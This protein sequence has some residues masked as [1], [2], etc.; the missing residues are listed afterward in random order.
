MAENGSNLTTN[1]NR[2]LAALL[3][4]RTAEDAAKAAGISRRQLFR[5][6]E[7]PK[8]RLAL[9]Q[10]ETERMSEASRRLLQGQH[11]ALTTLEELLSSPSEQV[12]RQAACDWLSFT[13]KH[14]DNRLDERLGKL[15]EAV[16]GIQ[17]Q[18]D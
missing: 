15:E 3:V 17:D 4:S 6:L 1:Q 16:Y 12:R 2:A 11:A 10:A 13:L 9:S 8:F 7:D 18:Q 5:Y 14:R